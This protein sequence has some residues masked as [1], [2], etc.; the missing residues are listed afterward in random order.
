MLLM[1]PKPPDSLE[2]WSL[3]AENGRRTAFGL[4]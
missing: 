3:L 1:L 4:L 2:K